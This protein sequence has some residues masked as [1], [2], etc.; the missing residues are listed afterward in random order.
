MGEGI[1]IVQMLLISEYTSLFTVDSVK[2]DIRIFISICVRVTTCK[3]Q[4]NSPTNGIPL[5][6]FCDLS[7][8]THRTR[9]RIPAVP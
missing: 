5:F 1:S 4:K 8:I 9:K 7:Y 3:R 2:V 6:N